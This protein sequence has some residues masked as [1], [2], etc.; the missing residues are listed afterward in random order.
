M[1]GFPGE[2][3]KDFNLLMDFV[4]ETEFEHLGAFRYS[5]EEGTRAYT[6]KGKVPAHVIEER[7]HALMSTQAGISL[8]KNQRL[9]GSSQR[10]LVEWFNEE[11]GK[12]WGRT[13]FQAPDIDGVVFID[14]GKTDPGEIVVAKITG[15]SEYDLFAEI[16][17]RVA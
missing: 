3:E 5:G 2:T 1:V 15:A 6:Y 12:L 13:T 8:K 10:V 7:Y 14:K 11:V 17:D 9:I 16:D 4:Q